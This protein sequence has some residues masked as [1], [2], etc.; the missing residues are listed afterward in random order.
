MMNKKICFIADFFKNEL[1]GG[2]ECNDNVLIQ[3]LKGVGYE[4][5]CV[6]SHHLSDSY[7]KE[8][9][10]FI[11]SNFCNLSTGH[12]KLL[13][14]K[15]YIIYEHDHKYVNTRDPS[16]FKN[17]EIPKENLV[18]V[19]FYR[20]AAAVVVLSKI[21]KKIIESNL[22]LNNVYSI[23]TSLWSKDKIALIEK[24]SKESQKNGKTCILQSFNPIKG[25]QQA[26]NYC[27]SKDIQFDIIE[28][29]ENS[30]LL[31]L[32]SAYDKFIFMPQVLETLSRIIVEA[33]MLNCKVMTKP[34]LIGG[35]SE[36]WFS[37]SGQ[38]LIDRIKIKVIDALELFENLIEEKVDHSEDNITVI[39][40]CYRRPQ[41]LEK[42][43]AAIREQ[44]HKAAEIWLWVNHHADNDGVDFGKFKVDKV[45]NN[46]YNWKYFGRF[47]AAML[48]KTKY[49]A[50]FDDD[51]IPGKDWFKN[52]VET[53][54]R[55][56]G[57]LG[58]VGVRIPQTKIYFGHKRIGWSN[59][60]EKVEKVD[61]VGHA[62]FL[63]KQ[64]LKYLWFEEPYTY[65]NGE[66]IHLSYMAQK[67]GNID[68]YVPPHPKDNIDMFSSTMGNELGI[69]DVA[70]SNARNHQVFYKQRND[71]VSN[72]IRN[73]WRIY[74]DE[75]ENRV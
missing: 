52:C 16:K 14:E 38:K 1:Y 54:K 70:S 46:D 2:A 32:M 61:L 67:H 26:I 12:Q 42:Q 63:E 30:K 53:S 71:I 58:G 22:K 73:G 44:T 19:E 20:N 68:T 29:A 34:K 9:E 8:N 51:T 4:V 7:I 24:L 31:K 72:A 55:H 36:E 21:C 27:R 74:I 62:W 33:K 49:V 45:F 13:K 18:N 66:D 48:A 64:W 69:D 35:A 3:H 15:K 37:L 50:F 47:S 5:E 25:T 75:G 17:F 23:G 57:I 40:N 43:I 39:L 41:N 60:N 28:P 11:V 10:K 6:Q 56:R 59:P 65:E